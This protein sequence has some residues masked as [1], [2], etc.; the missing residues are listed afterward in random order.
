MA[1][2]NFENWRNGLHISFFFF[3]LECKFVLHFCCY[4][5]QVASVVDD[6]VRPQRRHPSKLPCP[7]YKVETHWGLGDPPLTC[8]CAKLCLT[9]VILWTVACQASLSVGFSRQEYCNGLP[10][11]HAKISHALSPTTEES[12][13]GN[14]AWEPP[15]EARG[16]G[17]APRDWGTSGRHSGDLGFFLF[18]LLAWMLWLLSHLLK[19]TEIVLWSLT[20]IF[21]VHLKRICILLLLDGMFYTYNY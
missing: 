5:C 13:Q 15:T 14:F 3:A 18:L 1:S 16:N 11:K 7:I 17:T 20:K 4:C 2:L 10:R 8:M 6:S 19:F 21:H 12:G 9:F